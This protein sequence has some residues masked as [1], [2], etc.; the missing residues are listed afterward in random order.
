MDDLHHNESLSDECCP[1]PEG[2]VQRPG[3]TGRLTGSW[4]VHV[5]A[6]QKLRQLGLMR[7]L[8]WAE[9]LGNSHRHS[10][11][12]R[13]AGDGV[14][15]TPGGSRQGPDFHP[16][17]ITVC[18]K[19]DLYRRGGLERLRLLSRAAQQS[20]DRAIVRRQIFT[21]QLPEFFLQMGHRMAGR[22]SS[23]G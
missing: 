6:R 11:S 5:L 17:C 2:F 3:N 4:W 12:P 22:Q 14:C 21:L 16:V 15:L 10:L 9:S 20:S 23:L 18:R 7:E 1:E 8:L 13:D 19:C